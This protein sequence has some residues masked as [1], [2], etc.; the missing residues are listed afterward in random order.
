M[1]DGPSR[2]ITVLAGKGQGGGPGNYMMHNLGSSLQKRQDS[3]SCG[4]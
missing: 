4:P 1:G 3:S 2:V